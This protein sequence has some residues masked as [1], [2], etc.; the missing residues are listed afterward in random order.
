MPI[1]MY[2]LGRRIAGKRVEM[3]LT[4]QQLADKAHVT[5]R[6]IALL[7]TGKRQGLSVGTLAKVGQILGLS[8]DYLVYGE[9]PES[10]WQPASVA[11]VG[12]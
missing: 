11:L 12:T 5:Q 6:T 10:E 4:Q 2:R 3:G 7:E 9:D 1:D 8:L